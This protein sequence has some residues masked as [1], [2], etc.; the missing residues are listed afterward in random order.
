MILTLHRCC[1]SEVRPTIEANHYLHRWPIAK[2]LPFAYRL[3]VDGKAKAPDGRP[4]GILVYKKLQH[5]VQTGLF[6]RPGL[7][8]AWQVVDLAR[9]WVHPCLQSE[10]WHPPLRTEFWEYEDRSGRPALWG[11]NI[12][13]QM[14][15][16]SYK[17]VNRDWLEHHPPRFPGLPYHLRLILSYCDRKHHQGTGY[18]AAGFEFWGV[19]SDGKKD[20]YIKRLRQ[21]YWSWKRQQLELITV[22]LLEATA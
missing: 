8:T 12:F 22:D 15:A 16:L 6:G 1:E 7:I 10:D 19:T 4:L 9:V 3:E 14:V 2:S 13:S 11:Q 21:P 5:Q 17:R 20:I 18:K